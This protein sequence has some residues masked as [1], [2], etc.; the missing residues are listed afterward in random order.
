MLEKISQVST[1][2]KKTALPLTV[3]SIISS[4]SND[5]KGKVG[6]I[7]TPKAPSKIEQ[8]N[9]VQEHISEEKLNE[10]KKDLVA[11]AGYVEAYYQ[12]INNPIND[13]LSNTIGYTEDKQGGTTVRMAIESLKTSSFNRA[14]LVDIL[15]MLLKKEFDIFNRDSYFKHANLQTP[16][17]LDIPRDSHLYKKLQFLETLTDPSNKYPKFMWEL[18][19][20]NNNKQFNPTGTDISEF[21]VKIAPGS[22]PLNR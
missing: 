3:A 16:Q 4:C 20:S 6:N 21:N 12:S 15:V 18:F 17:Y 5:T 22:N 1:L 8:K 13:I 19:A 10:L 7:T 11:F 9:N 2:L 14:Q